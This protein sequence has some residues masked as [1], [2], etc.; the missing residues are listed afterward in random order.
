MG[1]DEFQQRLDFV[2]STPLLNRLVGFVPVDV[3]CRFEFGKMN[4]LQFQSS[5][6]TV[7]GIEARVFDRVPLPSVHFLVEFEEQSATT[8]MRQCT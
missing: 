5:L 8:W 2:P 1:V 7:V 6:V 3:P 4:M